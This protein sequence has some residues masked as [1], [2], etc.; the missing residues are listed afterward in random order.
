MTQ[1]LRKPGAA[2]AAASPWSVKGVDADT[3]LLAKQSA[4]R[5][6]LTIGA[7]L[8][9]AIETAAQ[10]TATGTEQ[11]AGSR[12]DEIESRLSQLE[13]RFDG[14]VTPLS[15]AVVKMAERIQKIPELEPS[16]EMGTVTEM[17]PDSARETQRGNWLYRTL[18]QKSQE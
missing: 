13:G 1:E 16:E 18:S 9:Q 8:K 4:R 6:G 2:S 5:A 12:L 11:P 10:A 17:A 7:W 14:T 15:R 3:R